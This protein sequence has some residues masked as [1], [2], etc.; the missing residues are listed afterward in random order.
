MEKFVEIIDYEGFYKI[1]SQGTFISMA[2]WIVRGN[3][4]TF[5]QE[6]Q[7]KTTLDMTGYY[8]VGL[9]KNG[10]LKNIRIHKLLAKH[11]IPNPNNYKYVRHLNDIPTDNRLENLAW[12][13][14]KDNVQ[15]CIRNGNFYYA[16]NMY[17]TPN[18][19]HP[20]KGKVAH[21]RGKVGE[22]SIHS[23]I[24]LNLCTGVYYFG[25]K[26]AADASNINV[27]TLRGKLCG[28]NYNNTDFIYV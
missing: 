18:F 23:K 1:G 4:K 7:I 16:I 25:C 28:L 20:S 15:D 3:G 22:Q 13:T 6:K 8:K 9:S 24:I 11:F 27:N 2:R 12:G 21:N 17:Q 19:I 10:K 14:P 26:E 5:I